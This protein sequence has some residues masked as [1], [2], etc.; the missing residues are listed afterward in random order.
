[1]SRAYPYPAPADWNLDHKMPLLVFMFTFVAADPE[2]N[3][4]NSHHPLLWLTNLRSP[5]LSFFPRS[6][7]QCF[8]AVFQR[9]PWLSWPRMNRTFQ[10][11]SSGFDWSFWLH[12][13]IPWLLWK[14]V[15]CYKRE[16]EGK[17]AWESE[18]IL[19]DNLR[20][21]RLKNVTENCF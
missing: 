9:I 18:A 21:M 14:K 17:K 1:M 12:S 13:Q 16:F 3:M 4:T 19:K 5:F 11:S 10:V 20:R 2:L 15:R 6:H 7:L 8:L